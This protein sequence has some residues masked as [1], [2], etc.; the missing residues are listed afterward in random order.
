MVV[1]DG[2]AFVK[3][4]SVRRSGETELSAIQMMAELVTKRAQEGPKRRH[5]L[6]H[7]GPC[8]YADARIAKRIIAEKFRCP[9]AFTHAQGSRGQ[10]ADFGPRHTVKGGCPTEE[11]GASLPYLSGGAFLHHTF[12][13]LRQ[14]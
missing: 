7:R 8:P 3:S 12:D 6:A 1:E 14:F 9:S 13:G 10:R 11:C 2:G 5:L 4:A